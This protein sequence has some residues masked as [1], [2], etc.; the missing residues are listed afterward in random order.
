MAPKTCAACRSQRKKCSDECLLPPHFPSDDMQRYLIVQKV[1]G[2]NNVV[3]MLKVRLLYPI[4]MLAFF[5]IS[6]I[7]IIPEIVKIHN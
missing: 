5:G 3:K 1:Y 6:Q 7:L 2:F 4:S